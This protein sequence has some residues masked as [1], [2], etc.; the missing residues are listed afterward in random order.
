MI[1]GYARVSTD[2]RIL[3]QNRGARKDAP[4]TENQ[5]LDAWLHAMDWPTVGPQF[6]QALEDIDFALQN[7]RRPADEARK[8]I[9]VFGGTPSGLT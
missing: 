3:L 1:Y 5:R 8:I 2:G 4:M 6:I 7:G 9:D